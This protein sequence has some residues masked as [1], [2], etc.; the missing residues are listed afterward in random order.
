MKGYEND[1]DY[2]E[3]PVIW[4]YWVSRVFSREKDLSL[5]HVCLTEIQRQSQPYQ[6]HS[7]Q[8]NIRELNMNSNMNLNSVKSQNIQAL[9]NNSAVPWN[10]LVMLRKK[11]NNK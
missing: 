11:I 3:D 1:R 4:V 9:S 6:D 8:L 2:D 7:M 5:S 10:V